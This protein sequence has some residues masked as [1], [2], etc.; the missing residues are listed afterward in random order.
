M[1]AATGA[2]GLLLSGC[3]PAAWVF[4]RIAV[5]PKPPIASGPPAQPPP[6]LTKEGVD[7]AV[8]KLDG[9][10]ENE[11]RK[12]GVPGAAVA[13]VYQDRVVYLKGFG[14]RQVGK[15]EV[16]DPDT[17]FQLASVSKPVASTVVAGVVGAGPVGWHDPV[18]KYDPDFAL[19]DAWVTKNVTIAD[20]FAHRSGL[21]DHAG[22]L[23]ED[24]GYDRDYILSHLRYE[25]LEPFRASYAYTNFGVTAAAVAVA[26]A[27]GTSWEDLSAKLLYQPLGMTST[28]SRFADYEKAANKAVTHV[29]VDG[30]WQAKYVRDP[31]AQSP[32]GGVSSS[33]KD[34]AQWLRLQLGN[35]KV[36]GKQIID[37]AALIQ[38]HLPQAVAQPPMAPAGRTGFY[39][40]GWNVGYDDHGR[41]RLNHSGAFALGEATNVTLLPSEQL[42]IVVLTNGEP[43]GLA[44]AVAFNFIDIAQDGQSTVDWLGLLGGVF[45]QEKT[46]DK[47]KI[48]YSKPPASPSPAKPA[49]AYEGTYTNDYYG[50]L[51]ISAEGDSL[52]MTLG[53]KGTQFPLRHYSGDTF[54]FETTGENAVGPSGVT[55][56]TND[57][58]ATTVRVKQLDKDGLGSFTRS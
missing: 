14:L 1:L 36:D 41:L 44:E 31:E 3:A 21:P 26:K 24:L 13:V 12:A 47:S 17:V 57:A 45:E 58:G 9:V 56:T 19:K 42:G 43:V 25:P 2:V 33:A 40:L 22:D 18:A 35:G 53:P 49:S 23:L 11:V 4:A 20:L 32:A 10:I 27:A 29:K 28:S 48:D 30:T 38:T 34:M 5:D 55:F 46:A 51:K 8:A 50:A 39:G 6:L 15:P 16:V 52:T 54:Y 37:E 7:A